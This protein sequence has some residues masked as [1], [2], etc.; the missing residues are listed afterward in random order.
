MMVI[1]RDVRDILE[2]CNVRDNS[3]IYNLHDEVSH[4]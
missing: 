2:D 3:E 1:I 4:S